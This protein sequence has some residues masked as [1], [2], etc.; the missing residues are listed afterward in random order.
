MFHAGEF[1]LQELAEVHAG[2]D[3]TIYVFEDVIFNVYF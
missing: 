1:A 3:I 2:L